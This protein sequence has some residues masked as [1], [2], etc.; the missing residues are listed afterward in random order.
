VVVRELDAI[1]AIRGKPLAC[2][3]RLDETRHLRADLVL[4]PNFRL[5]RGISDLVAEARKV[6]ASWA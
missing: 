6:V 3:H 1:V 2:L 5:A 4:A